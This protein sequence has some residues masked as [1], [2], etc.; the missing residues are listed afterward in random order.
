[1]AEVEKEVDTFDEEVEETVIKEEYKI[2]KKNSPFL[3][4]LVVTHSLEWPSLTAQWL[5]DVTR[6]ERKDYSVHRLVLGTH[7]SGEQNR[8]MIASLQ[9]P[10]EDAK[11]DSPDLNKC[12]QNLQ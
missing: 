1:M 5:P 11:M 8:L 10:K 4:D 3:Y 9:L 6:P 12:K 2:W 7:T